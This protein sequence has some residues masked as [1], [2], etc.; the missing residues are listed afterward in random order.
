M[1]GK[2]QDKWYA[3]GLAF[4]CQQSGNCCSGAPGYVWVTKA[5]QTA[6]AEFLGMKDGKLGKRYIRRV[7]LR[8]SLK[9]RPGGDCIFLERDGNGCTTCRI[10][11]VKPTQCR[12]WPFWDYN[13]K[14]PEHWNNA[15][16]GCPGIN[17][18]KLHTFVQIETQRLTHPP[19]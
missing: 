7:G 6:I 2:T 12:T 15:A 18:G 1:A 14:S 8:V 16:D 19:K 11:K 17:R 10:H 4:E 5:E 9:E 3:A 13:L